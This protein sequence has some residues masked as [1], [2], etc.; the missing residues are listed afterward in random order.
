M[1]T[2]FIISTR[3]QMKPHL[4]ITE[5]VVVFVFRSSDATKVR[6]NA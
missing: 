3:Y 1:H 2:E 6:S 5:V 4:S